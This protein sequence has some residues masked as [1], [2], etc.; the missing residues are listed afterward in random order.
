MVIC[1]AVNDDLVKE[2]VNQMQEHVRNIPG[3][4]GHSILTEEGGHMVILVTDWSNRQ[5]CLTYHAS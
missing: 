4:S 3:L 1:E 2:I 5:D